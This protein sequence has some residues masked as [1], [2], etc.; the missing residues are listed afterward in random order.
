MHHQEVMRMAQQQLGFDRK[1]RW[2]QLPESQRIKCRELL[3][4][5]LPQVVYAESEERR[6][7][8]R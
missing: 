1:E 5:M 4:E 8:E 2:D 6:I 7:H 3:S